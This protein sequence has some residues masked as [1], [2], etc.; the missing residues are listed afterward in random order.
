MF[1]DEAFS[2]ETHIRWADG[3]ML[4]YS[5][6]DKYSLPRTQYFSSLI[7]HITNHQDDH[8]R[9]PMVLVGN[10]A[11]QEHARLISKEEGE[12]VAQRVEC[13]H[14][15]ISVADSPDGVAQAMECLLK[16]IRQEYLKIGKRP[17]PF[18]NVKRV[19]KK[20]IYRSRSDTL[21]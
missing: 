6:T 3:Y 16:Q 12:R 4:L 11:D 21:Q 18:T 17:T 20:K 14:F 19:F 10:K 2:L 1:Q 8:E 13:D 9:L 7:Y 5:V 15:E